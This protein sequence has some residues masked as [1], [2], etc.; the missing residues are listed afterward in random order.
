MLILIA[1]AAYR[2]LEKILPENGK[3]IS[4]PEISL[5]EPLE[6][7]QGTRFNETGDI[8]IEGTLVLDATKAGSITAKGALAGYGEIFYYNTLA[9]GYIPQISIIA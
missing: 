6:V 8:T 9:S 7:M 5:I 4:K 2:I 1:V 3:F